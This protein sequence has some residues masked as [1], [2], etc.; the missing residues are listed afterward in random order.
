MSK[1]A[2]IGKPVGGWTKD[3]TPIH[4][5]QHVRITILTPRGISVSA[6][7]RLLGVGR[8]AL[9]NFLNGHVAA[10]PEM[11]S[12]IEHA[13]AIS[14][15]DLLDMQAAYDAAL[16]KTK[17][18]PANAMPYVAPFLGIKA[19]DIETWVGRSISARSRL[20]VFI[21]TLVNSTG[22]GLTKVDFPGNDDAQRPG[23]DGWIETTQPT[24]WIPIGNSGW[25]FGTDH[26]IKR[27]ADGDF[28]KA[29]RAMEKADRDE[30]TF[31]FVTP[32]HWP[33]KGDWINKQRGMGSWK[34]V[35]AYDS[36]DLE[37]WLEQSLAG[38]AWFANETLNPSDGVRVLEK[39]WTEW[40]EVASPPLAGALFA[41]AV[42]GAKRTIVSRLSKSP[43]EPTVIA[44]DSVEEALAFLAQL[45]G[46]A[47][48]A[49][50]E[51][52]RDRVLV[53]DRPGVLPKLAQGAKS[54][55][56]V[57][58]T[59]EVERELG[60]LTRSI[61]TIVVYPR[62]SATAEPHIILEPL[63][64]ETFRTALEG[65]GLQRDEAKTLS[66][67]SGR[68]LTV[69][70][71]RLTNVE[72]I[73]T[74]EWAADHAAAL[75]LIP[76]LFTGAWSS[77]NIAD[78]KVLVGLAEV[79]SYDELERLCQRYSSLNDP[80]LWSFGSYRGVISKIDL[81]FA[82]AKAV[83]RKDLERYFEMA[84]SVLA[85]DDPKL[86]LPADQRWAASIHGKFRTHSA[87]LREGVSETLVLL[88][89]HGGR[90]FRDRLGFDCESA[91]NRLVRD[92]LTPLRTRIL[93]AN[94]RDL[95]AYAEAAPDVFLSILDEDLRAEHPE[96]F[97]LFESA[98]TDLFGNGCPRTGLLWALE[99]LAWNPTTL[100]RTALILCRLAEIEIT[101]NWVNKPINS[102][103]SIFRAW[104]PQTA[105]DHDTR[106]R[107]MMLLSEKFPKVAWMICV[108]QFGSGP[109]TGDYS[110]K[111]RWR[112]DGHGYG[113]PFKTWGPTLKFM[114]AMAEMALSWKVDYTPQML[115][116]LIQRLYDLDDHF[117][118]K[119]WD[120][121]MEWAVDASDADKAIVREK[122]RVTVLSRRGIELAKDRDLKTLT[123]VAASAYEAL[124]PTDLLSKHE[125][126]FRQ[127]WIEE[128]PD[129]LH[130]EHLDYRKREER[131]MK[132]RANA[133]RE[134]FVARDLP[135][136]FELARNSKA[137]FQI[138]WL[139][140]KEILPEDE[141]LGFLLAALLPPIGPESWATKE[142][143]RG[144]LHALDNDKQRVDL[145]GDAGKAVSP[146]KFVQ[147]LLLAPFRRSTWNLVDQLDEER[148]QTYWKEV[149]PGWINDSSDEI[150]E[151][152]ERLIGAQRPRAA[153]ASVRLQLEALDR[154]LL[155]RLMEAMTKEGCDQ[156]GQY[157][158][159]RFYVERAFQLLDKCPALSLEQKAGL[160]Y[161]YIDALSQPWSKH[162]TVG[163][164]N[165]EKYIEQH[166]EL[167]VQAVVW[168]YRRSG[169]G[170]DPP[171]W[172]IAPDQVHH[173]A[174]RGYSL[175][176][177]LSSIPGHDDV[178][179]LQADKLA[180]WVKAVRDTCSEIDR[181][182]VAD[183]CLG[184]LLSKAPIGN[185]G[186]WPCEP[187]R[188]VI[189]DV[190]SKAMADGVHTGL[191]N[192]RGATWRGDGGDQERQLANK[193][194]G[195]ANAL[196]YSYP[197][198]A[199]EILMQL[200]NTYEHEARQ[201]DTEA[202]VRRRL[203]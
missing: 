69:L 88:A 150:N 41:D 86:D 81:L 62:N 114:S 24:Q 6:A 67:E 72:A 79:D 33:G 68:S 85:E 20:S 181:L 140:S 145:L 161:A 53:F 137:A 9:S 133:L 75:H 35:R 97:G 165:L 102:L 167:F 45:F 11:A 65:M 193:Y 31:V 139:M 121:L 189:E 66:L 117:Q 74:P 77:T 104:M 118:A 91:V 110:H 44:A 95:A 18:V 40:A 52:Y 108:D 113:E 157:Q 38:Q 27:K 132:L 99:S 78:Q 130:D 14:A 37:Q 187:V 10:T 30:T 191:Y 171:A 128:S 26:D 168:T 173:F 123:A 200:A 185:D 156:S 84:K 92:L 148:G 119:V 186:V 170:E 176:N 61:H 194:R 7:A 98:G 47:G 138:G 107:T 59:R 143:I 2:R 126:L 160:E 82:V 188:R 54:L 149:A 166:P 135:G 96:C 80:P 116:D 21:R 16:A 180:T 63:S 25:E 164:P 22:L 29:V 175:L 112:N 178:G 201:E 51:K 42:I 122:I 55:I 106:L 199:N 90:L 5:G 153:F 147:L 60:P 197:F 4:P 142:L 182:D 39:C 174:E 73:R 158:V 34:D 127:Q 105:A 195:W 109:R 134:V 50:L 163:I 179:E 154:E 13:F 144:A 183:A 172:K 64:H 192:S 125:W 28:A 141:I 159:D 169:E 70:R 87:A 58:A 43:S 162:E 89:V 120:R 202:G 203:G 196:Q 136:V 111:P 12:R 56:A 83:T 49:D 57:A 198:L 48:G 23:W 94:A 190:H 146:S 1:K 8:P 93:E 115:C 151:A 3:D 131:I 71:R 36:S 184:R 103:R 152:V 32:R 124:E 129:E 100:P 101:D 46:P 15:N 17:G 19:V 177:A 155:F 76:F